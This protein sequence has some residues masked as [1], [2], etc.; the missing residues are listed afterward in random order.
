VI[1]CEVCVE[2]V[3]GAIAAEA[4][5]AD[6]I[7]LCAGLVEGGTTPSFG[8]I[9]RVL[10]TLSIPTVVLIRPRGGDFLYTAEE[11]EALLCDVDVIRE[12]GAFGIATG[13]LTREGDVDVHA[14]EQVMD[15]AGSLSVTFHRAFD[16][17]RDPHRSLETLIHLGVHRVLTSGLE[18]SV[19]E[20]LELL[21]SLVE[22][23]KGRT[24]IMPGG[25]IRE[26]NIRDI[27]GKTGVNE[28]HFTA[29]AS[30]ESPMAHRNTRPLMGSDR[31]PG[32]YGRLVTAPEGVRRIVNSAAAMG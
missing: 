19:P 30:L 17:T 14:M 20:G 28:V 27:I 21:G 10:D 12:S 18:R 11:L 8:T 4:G 25:G 2:G 9:S 31:V 22:L 16:M 5:G 26:D 32:E 15:A 13:V 1:T 23:A 24:S 3:P 6:R 7:E 29:F